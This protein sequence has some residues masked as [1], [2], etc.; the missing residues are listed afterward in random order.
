MV[1][2]LRPLARKKTDDVFLK[3]GNS[4]SVQQKSPPWLATRKKLYNPQNAEKHYP[5]KE[6]F[7]SMRLHNT[8]KSP[9]RN[10]FFFD[11]HKL[12][13]DME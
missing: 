12:G 11:Y 3:L 8:N 4:T 7:H 5:W 13:W 2:S 6:I 10:V 9:V 1:A